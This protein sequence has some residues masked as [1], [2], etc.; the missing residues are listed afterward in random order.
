MSQRRSL[1]ALESCS[2]RL[3]VARS[4][5]EPPKALQNGDT[6]V[7]HFGRKPDAEVTQVPRLILVARDWC[8]SVGITNDEAIFIGVFGKV[9]T[10]PSGSETHLDG[11]SLTDCGNVNGKPSL[12]LAVSGTSGERFTSLQAETRNRSGVN[13]N[14]VV[15]TSIRAL[16]KDVASAGLFGG[17]G[18]VNE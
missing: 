4:W 8:L 9:S 2:S 18:K 14:L 7:V 13:R 12:M 10:S 16:H 17:G 3:L 5:L 15:V 11:A 1:R 6:G